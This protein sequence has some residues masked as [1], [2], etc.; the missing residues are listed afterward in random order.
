MRKILK[1]SAKTARYLDSLPKI[2]GIFLWAKWSMLEL[3]WTGRYNKDGEP[4]VYIYYDANGMCDEYRLIPI[5]QASSGTFNGWY[6]D[7]NT[8]HDIQLELNDLLLEGVNYYD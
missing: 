2:Y 3:P 5:S 8:A 4:L 6:K 7:K 1:S